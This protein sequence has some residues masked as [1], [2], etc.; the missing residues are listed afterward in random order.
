VKAFLVTRLGD[1]GFL[2][3]IFVL[4]HEAG[5]F[6]I[7][8]ILTAASAGRLD[9]TT[10]AVAAVLLLCGVVG[11]SAQFPLHSWLPD[12]MPGPTPIT[13]L[14]HAATMVAAGV[15]F[16]AEMLPVFLLSAVTTWTLALI[17]GI[18]MVGGALFACTA[19]DLKRVLAWSTVSQ[20]AYMFGALSV[21]GYAAGVL[22]LLAHGIFKALLFLGA[23]VVIEVAGTRRLD[24]LAAWLRRTGPRATVPVTFWT[25]TVGLAA[26]AG[27]PPFVGFFSK[28]RVLAVAYERVSSGSRPGEGLV[29]LVAGLGTAVLT[30]GYATRLWLLL[31]GSVLPGSAAHTSAEG[32]TTE[33]LFDLPR[34]AG[35][36]WTVGRAQ[37]ASLLMTGPLVVLAVLALVGGAAVVD[38][39]FL[40]IHR[41]HLDWA[42]AAISA[43]L[44]L[45]TVGLTYAQWRRTEGRDPAAVL[46]R[47]RRPLV[48]ELGWD[49]LVVGATRALVVAGTR[50]VVAGDRDVVETYVDGAADAASGA[51]G[52]V[53]W[54][55]AGR[56]RQY[57]GA[58]VVGAGALGLLMAVLA[59]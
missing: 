25:M 20:L 59:R 26:L 38:P 42:M 48:G 41:A 53:R 55:H 22:H 2:F 8:P 50:G 17:S 43:A 57:L 3:G 36:V 16:V 10:T 52:L 54:A 7:G 32:P 21:G 47:L 6:D 5:T 18:T 1:V 33:Y 4:G 15:F 44:V 56:I 29:V 14:I 49:H 37:E 45:L 27:L 19:G 12:A 51:G 58:V 46:G 35:R 30:A 34:P 13:A 31:F 23:G 24:E 9:P 28:D 39:A 11:K 40:G